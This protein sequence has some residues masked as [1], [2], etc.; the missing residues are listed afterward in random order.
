V[1]YGDRKTAMIA[2]INS[3]VRK[4][5]RCVV[6]RKKPKI[7]PFPYQITLTNFVS[8]GCKFEV[9]THVE[10]GRVVSLGGEEEFIR[11]FLSEIRPGDVFFDVGS[12]VGL[13]ALHAAI[14]GT[15]VWAFEP[16]PSYRGRLIRNVIINKLQS[17]IEVL[18]WAV[19]DQKGVANIYT[20]GLEGNRSPSLNLIGKRSAIVV[21]TD[22]I[23]NAIADNR[24][25]LPTLVKID[26]EGAEILALRGMNKLLIS[27]DAP[28]CLF[29]ELHPEFL[30]G[31]R[32]SIEECVT[33]IESVGYVV[34]YSRSRA[35]Q[36]HYIYRK[37]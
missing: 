1:V 20:D 15:R 36:L 4:I 22:S 29:I 13:F 14:Y 16:D 11:L 25:P 9:T 8:E 27:K 35:D 2:R 34:E 7:K 32:S 17:S 21:N 3:F 10:E 24:L 18:E 31:F 28:R 37:G 26:I 19:S 5:I 30:K 6:R 33:I 12:C 23:D